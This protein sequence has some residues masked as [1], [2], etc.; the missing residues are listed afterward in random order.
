VSQRAIVAGSGIA[1]GQVVSDT[2]WSA[3][4]TTRKRVVVYLPP[5]YLWTRGRRYAAAYYLHG[6]YGGEDDWTTNG[7][8]A[9]VMDSLIAAGMPE[10]I[11]VMPDGDDGWYTTWNALGNFSECMRSPP[12]RQNAQTYCVPWP[13]YDDYIARDL[14]AHVDSAYRTLPARAHRGIAGLSMGGYGAVTLALA[15]GDVFSVAASHS[16]VLAPLLGMKGASKGEATDVDSLQGRWSVGLWP[17]LRLAFGGRDLYGW[18]ARDPARMA[19][20]ALTRG[21]TLPPLMIDAGSDDPF[22]PE[23]RAF[24][25]AVRA[26]GE[27]VT[28]R[29]W[30]GGHDWD[31]WR[32]HVGE[33]LAWMAAHI[34]QRP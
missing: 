30:P 23:S 12:P 7:R 29:E 4:M 11:V 26:L 19:K 6:A 20:R 8:L 27:P 13:K 3:I 32:A 28:Y 15:Y 18:T 21:A 22:T 2:F 31:Y 16:G 5:S 10:M 25:A 33:S 17:G 14:V 9:A 1:Q 24:V 34:T